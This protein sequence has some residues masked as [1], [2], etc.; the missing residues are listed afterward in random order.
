MRETLTML[1]EAA[2]R[3]IIGAETELSLTVLRPPYAALGVGTL[4]V[5]RL[6]ERVPG[7]LE[8]TVGYDRYER[9]A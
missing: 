8:L 5:L 1:P 3:R 4:R 9:L 7:Q 6:R 2:A